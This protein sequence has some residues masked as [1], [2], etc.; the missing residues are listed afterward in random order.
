MIILVEIF[1]S[2]F[3]YQIQSFATLSTPTTATTTT[4]PTSQKCNSTKARHANEY[5]Q[6]TTTPTPQKRCSPDNHH[7]R[8]GLIGLIAVPPSFNFYLSRY[9]RAVKK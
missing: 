3:K 9:T 1:V 2:Y 4:A 5:S 7:G 6:C 8:S